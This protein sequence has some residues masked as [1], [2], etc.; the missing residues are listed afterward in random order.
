MRMPYIGD[1]LIWAGLAMVLLATAMANAQDNV[2]PQ[3]GQPPAPAYGPDNTA[4]LPGQNPPISGMEL[5]GLEPQATPLSY[6]QPSVSISEAA[7]SNVEG[8]LGGSATHGVTRAL[9]GL[10]LQRLWE[11][12]DLAV[13]YQGGVAYYTAAGIGFTQIQQFG[14]NQKVTWKRGQLGIH[15]SFSYLPEGNF[16]GAYGSIGAPGVAVAEGGLGSLF[17]GGGALGSLGQVPRI[18][19]LALVD[20]SEY[21][22][23]R[24]VFTASAG[25][26]LIHFTGSVPQDLAASNISSF[27]GSSEISAQAGLS[28]V[29]GPHDQAAIVYGY[30]GFNFSFSGLAFHSHVVQVMWGHRISGRMDF[31]IGAGP[32]ITLLGAPC[33][34]LDALL[35]HP[36]CSFNSAGNPVGS[37]PDTTL[38]VAGR[39]SLRYRFPKTALQATFDRYSTAGSGLFAG[40]ESNVGRLSATRPLTRVWNGFADLGY[41]RNSRL[42]SVPVGALANN[43]NYGFVGG[44]VERMFGRNFRA[45][46]S[47]QFN[48]LSFDNS[49]CGTGSI[50]C[51]RIAQRHVGTIGLDWMPRPIRID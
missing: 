32:Q 48:E 13:D 11:N 26:G 23:P 49:F 44:G 10:T 43:Y 25:Y 36:H 47:Y 16:G 6:L 21:L 29:M 46:A 9:G 2:E 1:K 18:M 31:L 41:A 39:V 19:N 22:S 20:V 40:A 28:R 17:G 50:S 5:P 24:T 4:P 37:I 30:Q 35:A 12:Y 33:T 14:V 3:E 51:S 7:D 27:I 38:G 42:Q 45:Y 15:D 8:N 34:F